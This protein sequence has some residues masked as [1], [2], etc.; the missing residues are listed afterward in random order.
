NWDIGGSWF[1]GT[2]TFSGQSGVYYRAHFSNPNN[3][4][5]WLGDALVMLDV[6]GTMDFY[7]WTGTGKFAPCDPFGC[8]SDP[9]WASKGWYS[10]QLYNYAY[11][12]YVTLSGRVLDVY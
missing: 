1:P 4:P 5:N 12:E 2:V 11:G 7:I 3:Y 6:N 10:G 8:D 9:V